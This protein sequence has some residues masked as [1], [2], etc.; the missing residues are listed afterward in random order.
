MV[1]WSTIPFDQAGY[2]RH[3]LATGGSA[4]TGGIPP[5]LMELFSQ[6]LAS[7]GGGAAAPVP[8]TQTQAG[9]QFAAS[10]QLE[11]IKLQQKLQFD[12]DFALAKLQGA[13]AKALE[14][15]R[16]AFEMKMK[17]Q[18]LEVQ[19][20]TLFAQTYGQDP[21]R[22]VLIATG[23]GGQLAGGVG[24]QFKSLPPMAGAKQYE[25]STEKALGKVTGTN[26]DITGKGVAGLPSVYQTA[27][28]AVQ[29]GDAVTTLLRSA[30]GIGNESLGGGISAEE[31]GKR[32]Q[33]VT[34]R[35]TL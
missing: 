22:A 21:V 30:F 5:E 6:F 12:A 28:Q 14:Q 9:A 17:Q 10:Q 4:D 2:T 16:Q 34:P 31:F 27:Q 29:G 11:Q 35:G 13:N 3:N 15:M 25:Q 19:R 33:S 8:Y 1:D 18:E 7:G 32:I 24:G 20:Q 23:M 26:I